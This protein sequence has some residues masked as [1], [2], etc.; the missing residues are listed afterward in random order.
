MIEFIYPRKRE[1]DYDEYKIDAANSPEWDKH[2]IKD[3]GGLEKMILDGLYQERSWDDE[4]TQTIS[5]AYIHHAKTYMHDDLEEEVEWDDDAGSVTQDL[6]QCILGSY[7]YSLEEFANKY[8]NVFTKSG[9]NVIKAITFRLFTTYQVSLPEVKAIF[10]DYPEDLCFSKL[11]ETREELISEFRQTRLG[12]HWCEC[13]MLPKGLE[14]VGKYLINHRDSISEEEESRFFYLLD[15]ICIITDILK[16]NAT[17][18]WLNVDYSVA[19]KVAE[20][21]ADGTSGGDLLANNIFR[22]DI[23]TSN[24]LLVKLRQT[25]ANAVGQGDADRID[26]THAN[27]WYWLYAGLLDAGFLETRSNRENAVTDIGFVRQM[28]LWFPDLLDVDDKKKIRQI[29]NGLSTERTKWTMNGKL[30]S[31][32]DIEANKRRLTAM[33]ETKVSRIVSVAY[34]GLYVPLAALKQEIERENNT[35]FKE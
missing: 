25:I 20:P 12:K 21:A 1:V 28:A 30:I 7:N 19:N 2:L 29:C 9:G 11:T 14:K 13:I 33:K 8:N 4:W 22:D 32:V 26:L 3:L 23:F 18:Y 35:E 10:E 6:V 15:E 5:Q 17:K 24:D 34:Q 31:L 16:G 27:E